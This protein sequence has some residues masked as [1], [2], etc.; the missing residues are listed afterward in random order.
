MGRKM[1][2]RAKLNIM[3]N[4]TVRHLL[5]VGGSLLGVS[6]VPLLPSMLISAFELLCKLQRRM[7]RMD[8]VIQR[9]SHNATSYQLSR[10]APINW[11]LFNHRL[12]GSEPRS[13]FNRLLNFEFCIGLLPWFWFSRFCS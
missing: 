12:T 1:A 13:P 10:E 8:P 11:I 5:R 6:A 7:S 4:A 3:P 9:L 2:T